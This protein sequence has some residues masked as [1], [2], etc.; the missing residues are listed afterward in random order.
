MVETRD[1]RTGITRHEYGTVNPDKCRECLDAIECITK[2]YQGN[3][4]V[5][6]LADLKGAPIEIISMPTRTIL[7]SSNRYA[8]LEF[9]KLMNCKEWE[10]D[11]ENKLDFVPK[12]QGGK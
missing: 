12:S 11:N 3:N 2:R 10:Y 4:V 8:L 6:Y 5:R 7:F 1:A 9:S